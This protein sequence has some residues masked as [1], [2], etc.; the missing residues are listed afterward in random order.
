L[1]RGGRDLVSD[2]AHFPAENRLLAAERRLRGVETMQHVAHARQLFGLLGVDPPHACAG[3]RA[4]E[5]A[6]VEHAREV[7]VLRVLG[8]AGDA[9]L[10][11]DATARFCDLVELGPRRMDRQVLALDEDERLE[12]LALE[13]LTTPDDARH[14]RFFPALTPALT[15]FG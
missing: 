12:D 11:V 14:Q 7:D 10:A 5:H 6:D 15:M 1:R 4:A 13:L 2:E 3:I 9:L 8:A